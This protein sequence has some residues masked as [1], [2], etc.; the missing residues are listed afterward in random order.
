MDF[1]IRPQTIRL[2][3]H[4]TAKGYLLDDFKDTFTRYIPDLSVT[5]SQPNEPVAFSENLSVTTGDD[6]T[7]RKGPKAASTKDCDVVT[8]KK[9]GIGGLGDEWGV[10][11]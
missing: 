10:E 7:D 4:N 1:E 8:D 5:T 2:D 6:V 9:G 3:A 11:I